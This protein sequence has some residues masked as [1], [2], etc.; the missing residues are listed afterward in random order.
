MLTNKSNK[1]QYLLYLILLLLVVFAFA[2]VGENG[3][4]IGYTN[5]GDLVLQKG[6]IYS[7]MFNTWPPAF[8]ILSVPLAIINSWSFVFVRILWICFMFFCYF[9]VIKNSIEWLEQKPINYAELFKVYLIQPY[10]LLALFISCRAFM[11][12]L[13]YMQINIVMLAACIYLIAAIKGEKGVLS[14]VLLGVSIGAK[15]YNVLLLPVLFLFRKWRLLLWVVV[16]IALTF[17]LSWLV[18]GFDLSNAYMHVWY[19]KVATAK[20]TI[21]HRNQSL[22][23][24]LTRMF[25]N[26]NIAVNQFNP[27]LNLEASAIQKIQIGIIALFG[28]LYL[29][30][31][32]NLIYK[33]QPLF[34]YHTFVLVLVF[35][36][37]IVPISW[38]ANY[39][40]GLPA[41]FTLCF[42]IWKHQ[43]NKRTLYLFVA[44]ALSLCL[45]NEA[46][47]GRPGMYFLENINILIIGELL[48]FLSLISL[49]SE[50]KQKQFYASN[51]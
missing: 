19:Q 36:P 13:I 6:D 23:S 18:F 39:I 17:I 26:E 8:S 42:S 14:A 11:D 20:H 49:M 21:E 4:F 43:V 24:G 32:Y 40:Y 38:K 22:I 35:I 47:I 48:L 33:A 44:A 50:L 7:D 10:Y 1:Y 31:F 25:S 46:L 37:V 5:A 30:L 29:S 51:I 27:V 45:S 2:K 15:A 41:F 28:T 3:D 16:G 12:N 34:V 9:Y